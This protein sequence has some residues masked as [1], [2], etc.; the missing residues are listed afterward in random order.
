MLHKQEDIRVEAKRFYMNL[1]APN[2]NEDKPTFDWQPTKLLIEEHKIK[3][4]KK[5]IKEEIM[6]AI[7]SCR[8]SNAPDPDGFTMTFFKASWMTIK[9]DII[10]TIKY[11]FLHARL[12]D[13][14]NSTFIY[15]I[16]K[17]DATSLF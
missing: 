8:E 7:F 15:L 10:A 2:I 3:L 11:F 4:F 6:H 9:D 16:P 1:L 5:V 13:E 14:I 17:K 12:L